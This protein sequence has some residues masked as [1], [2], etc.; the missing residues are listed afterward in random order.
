MEAA[1]RGDEKIIAALDGRPA[2]RVVAVPGRLI[3]FVV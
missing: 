3:N 1:A 2:K